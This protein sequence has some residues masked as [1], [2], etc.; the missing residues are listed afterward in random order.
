MK[1]LHVHVSVNDLAASIRFYQTLFGAQPA[2]TKPD[3]A[4]WMLEDPR[5]NFAISTHRQPVGVNHLGFQVDTDEELRGM[6]AQL[7][8]AD[9]RMVEENEQPCCYA[10]SDKYWVTDPS[11]I[12][13]ETFHT[14][15]NIH[16]YGEDTPVFNHGASAV[17]VQ[18]QASTGKSACCVPAE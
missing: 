15:G 1:R 9:A 3:Y 12:A 13:W 4:K 6:R 2:V 16:V 18:N 8:A 11:G 7:E 5:V 17:P 10:R 14:L